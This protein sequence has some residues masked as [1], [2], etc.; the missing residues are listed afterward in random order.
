MLYC[1][2][3]VKDSLVGYAPLGQSN[4][5]RATERDFQELLKE[6]KHPQDLEL[7]IMG[8]Y[9]SETGDINQNLKELIGKG[10]EDGSYSRETD[11]SNTVWS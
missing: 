1:L 9:D 2:I 10:N 11:I 6:S 8:T 3:S 7:Y 5:L 4:N